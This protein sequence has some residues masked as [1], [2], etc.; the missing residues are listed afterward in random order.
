MRP[1][2]ALAAVILAGGIPA[3]RAQAAELEIAPVLLTLAPGQSS[4]TIE[5]RNNGKAPVAIQARA[6][7]WT[8]LADDDVL[9]PTQEVILSPPIFTVAAGASQTLRLLLRGNRPAGG[10]DRS[11]RLMLEEVPTV[12]TGNNG[13]VVALRVSLPVFAASAAQPPPVLT[14]QAARAPDGQVMLTAIN[15]GQ[16]S[17]RVNAMSVTLPDGSHPKIIAKGKSPYILP[18][19]QRRWTLEAPGGAP[20]APVRLRITTPAGTTEEALTP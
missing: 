1:I 14:W 3:G 16:S 17:T 5:L 6:F 10:P 13:V 4:A 8:Q 12:G 11:Y 15:S 2:T 9:T 19:V 7:A 20:G 18:G